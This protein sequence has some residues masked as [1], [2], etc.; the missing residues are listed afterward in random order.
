MTSH[1]EG[2]K[3]KAKKKKKRKK[4]IKKIKIF[5]WLKKI[6]NVLKDETKILFVL[7]KKL[8]KLIY[9]KN[10]LC[11]IIIIKLNYYIK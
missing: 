8:M 4:E 6:R 10:N 11:I 7:I 9:I 3:L 1:E 5:L 2:Y